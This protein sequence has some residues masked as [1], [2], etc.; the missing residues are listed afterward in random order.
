MARGL[1]MTSKKQ[2]REGEWAEG[3][4]LKWLCPER[5]P[6]EADG[7]LLPAAAAAT[8]HGADAARAEDA[9]GE[10]AIVSNGRASAEESKDRARVPVLV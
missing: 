5:D 7:F 2:V 3:R 9:V 8:L 1:Y 4:R 10:I 6:T